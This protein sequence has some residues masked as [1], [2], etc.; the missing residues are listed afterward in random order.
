MDRLDADGLGPALAEMSRLNAV[1]SR[2][3]LEH[4]VRA[5][6]DVTGFGLAG[7]GWNVARGSGVGLRFDYATLPVHDGFLALARAGVTTGCTD[8][9][10]R[11][12]EAVL[13][14][15]RGLDKVE[16]ALLFDPQTSGPLLL[17]APAD[18]AEA[19]LAALTASGHRAAIVGEV[20][21]GPA[22]L[23]VV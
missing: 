16:R 9:N 3:A 1:A 22:R 17:S 10:R 21:P 6:T 18:R 23:E 14:D 12:V 15:R 2:L 8:A 5:A 13:T 4:G 11:N 19:L 7:H 20:L